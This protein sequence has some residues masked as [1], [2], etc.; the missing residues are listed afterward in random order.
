[1]KYRRVIGNQLSGKKA[2]IVVKGMKKQVEN[3]LASSLKKADLNPYVGFK[4]LHYS[5]TEGAGHLEIIIYKKTNDALE[6]GCRTL[7]DTACAPDD[8]RTLDE[9]L[10]FGKDE[11]EKSIKIEIVDDNEWEPDED[12]LVELYDVNTSKRL[13][14]K[15][16]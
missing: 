15:D 5:V 16:S 14:G 7:D 9:T 10:V 4:C 2:F 11:M 8:Y 6:I 3:K 1:M 13:Q 12:F